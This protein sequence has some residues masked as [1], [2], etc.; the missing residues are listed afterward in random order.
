MGGGGNPIV[1]QILGERAPVAPPLNPPLKGRG[2]SSFK[3]ETN[4]SISSGSESEIIF[5][6]KVTACVR[7]EITITIGQLYFAS[8][9]YCSRKFDEVTL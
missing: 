8:L 3:T 7:N 1:D 2:Q 5:K 4:S 6:P 9:R